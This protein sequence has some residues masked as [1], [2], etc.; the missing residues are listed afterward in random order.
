MV[1]FR[2]VQASTQAVS[3]PVTFPIDRYVRAVR[4][5]ADVPVLYST[6]PQNPDN[7]AMIPAGVPEYFLVAHGDTCTVTLPSGGS[8]GNVNIA[9]LT[10]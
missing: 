9:F 4:V 8:A 7:G 3:G 10:H 1:P 5:V 6:S 2:F